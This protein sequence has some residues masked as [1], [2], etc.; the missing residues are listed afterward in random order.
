MDQNSEFMEKLML[1]N[2]VFDIRFELYDKFVIK[3]SENIGVGDNNKC[4]TIVVCNITMDFLPKNV[5][6]NYL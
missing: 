3:D 4:W 5:M 1:T 2:E 6:S